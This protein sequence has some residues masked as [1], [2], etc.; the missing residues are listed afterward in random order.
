MYQANSPRVA[1]ETLDNETIVIDT[2]TG[3]YYTLDGIASIM[4]EALVHGV[5]PDRIATACV[6]TGVLQAKEALDF[7]Q[8]LVSAE[9]L[10]L[11]TEPRSEIEFDTSAF[12]SVKEG[13]PELKTHSDLH[14]LIELDPIHEVD[15]AQGWPMQDL[16]ET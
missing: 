3:F 2:S 1:H 16:H 7:M 9:L 11:A 14:G 12:R 5:S 8:Q 10:V 15:P 13:K 4:W 6:E